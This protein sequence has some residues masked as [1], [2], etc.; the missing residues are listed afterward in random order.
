MG[1]RFLRSFCGMSL[2][3]TKSNYVC[4]DNFLGKPL[5]E[6]NEKE[7]RKYFDDYVDTMKKAMGKA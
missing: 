1:M 6:G 2:Y 5:K 3:V 7:C 4:W